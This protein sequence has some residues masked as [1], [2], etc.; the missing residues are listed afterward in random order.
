LRSHRAVTVL[1]VIDNRD[2]SLRPELS[3]AHALAI[4]PEEDS[5]SAYRIMTSLLPRLP[6]GMG[7]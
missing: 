6:S 3:G 4:W 5:A 2:D 7:P 1:R